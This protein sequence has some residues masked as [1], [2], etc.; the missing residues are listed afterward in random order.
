M[1]Y[2]ESILSS[3]RR[4]T[5]AIDLHSRKLASEYELTAPQ[6]VC[7]RQLSKDGPLAPSRLAREVSLSQATITGIV[8]RLERAGLVERRRDQKDRRQVSIHVTQKGNELVQR[9]PLPLQERFA[10]RLEKLGQQKQALIDT[11]LKEI[12]E[13]MEA[14]ELDAAPVITAG[15]VEAEHTQVEEF[16]DASNWKKEDKDL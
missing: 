11:T 10:G 5:R 14:T 3:L 7:L 15:N 1:N 2:D 8:D 6:L 13:M 16:L 9:A 12:V 4:I